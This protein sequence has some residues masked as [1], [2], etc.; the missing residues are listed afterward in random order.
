MSRLTNI[1]PDHAT[2]IV[3]VLLDGIQAKLGMTPNMIKAMA[4][5]PAVLDAYVQF[6]G[7]LSKGGLSSKLREQIA[8]AV[9]Q[10]NECEYCLAA[11]SA[12]G[13]MV[14]LTAEQIGDSRIG[15]AVDARTAATLRLAQQIVESRGLVTDTDL[16]GARSADLNDAAIAE[17]VANVA[18]NIFTNYFNKVAATDVDF[19]RVEPLKANRPSATS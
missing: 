19:P 18:L 2:G 6:S 17:I 4:V 11:H 10:A 5:S 7:A 16:A 9:G 1:N 13:K 8:L 14:G 15:T 12:I 3:K